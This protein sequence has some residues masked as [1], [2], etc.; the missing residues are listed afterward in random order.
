MPPR[1]RQSQ[2]RPSRSRAAAP[3]PPTDDDF[4]PGGSEV[5]KRS[6]LSKPEGN[7]NPLPPG[8]RNQPSADPVDPDSVPEG[9]VASAMRRLR[10]VTGEQQGAFTPVEG[11]DMPGV[12]QHGAFDLASEPALATNERVALMACSQALMFALR[13]RLLGENDEVGSWEQFDDMAEQALLACV[14]EDPF[15]SLTPVARFLWGSTGLMR[16]PDDVKRI[17]EIADVVN[18]GETEEQ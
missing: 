9:N 10:E 12:P 5:V 14:P 1:Q 16:M 17:A 8:R 6:N 13:L 4:A 15:A 7:M 18:L 3:P 2:A 11:N